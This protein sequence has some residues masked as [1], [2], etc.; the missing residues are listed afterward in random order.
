MS[1]VLSH[2]PVLL[3][4]SIE[5]LQ[6]KRGEWYV[7]ATLGAGG[8]SRA[9]LA[10][11]GRVIGIDQDRTAL[12]LV[13][14]ETNNP[15][16]HLIQ[17]NFKNLGALVA[18]VTKDPVAGILFDLGVSSMQFDT[19]SRG[20]SFRA[21]APLDMRMDQTQKLTAADIVN[22]MS[23]KDLFALFVNLAQEKN[24]RA[25]AQAIIRS[26]QIKPIE[27]TGELTQIVLGLT[28]NPIGHLHPATKVFQALRMAVNGEVDALKAALT[29]TPSLLIQGGRLVIISFHEGEDRLVKQYIALHS[30]EFKNLLKHPLSP[31]AEEIKVNPRCRS[32]RLR[33]AE[34]L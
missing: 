28:G 9:I 22:S 24:A 30:S 16:L 15:G 1:Q 33:S 17:G 13:A 2:Q 31:R 3:T 4:E 18:S 34:R 20:F 26:R 5:Y 10:A 21:D 23:F 11:G 12:D 27:T 7:D 19:P 14:N 25:L 6:V 8:H 29:Q 32:A